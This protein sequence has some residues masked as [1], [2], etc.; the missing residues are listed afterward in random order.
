MNNVILKEK[1][2]IENLIYE[3]RGVQVMLGSEIVVTKWHVT[4]YLIY[5]I[6]KAFIKLILSYHFK[7]III[8]ELIVKKLLKRY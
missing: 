7:T 8:F 6:L 1:I 5:L 3:I 4:K 2:I